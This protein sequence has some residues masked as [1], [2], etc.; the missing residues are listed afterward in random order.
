MLTLVP[1]G[2]R[3]DLECR[4]LGDNH[5]QE[6]CGDDANKGKDDEDVLKDL[7]IVDV[8]LERV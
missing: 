2:G 5:E 3:A 7:A 1:E 6:T 8:K 4:E